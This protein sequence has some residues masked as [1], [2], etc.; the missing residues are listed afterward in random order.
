M[1]APAPAPGGHHPINLADGV[2]EQPG[3]GLGMS[4]SSSHLGL[5]GFTML[6]LVLDPVKKR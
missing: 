5:Y 1:F 4:R 3:V 2:T 6:V